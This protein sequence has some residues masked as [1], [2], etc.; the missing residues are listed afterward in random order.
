MSRRRAAAWFGVAHLVKAA[1]VGAGV[2]AGL[3]ARWAPV[4]VVAAALVA[5][6]VASGLG[7][8]AATRWADIAAR[9]AAMGA[10]AAGLLATTALGVTVSWLLGVYGPVGKGGGLLFA[11]VAALIFPY[12]V[13]L[14]CIELL[15]LRSWAKDAAER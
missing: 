7:L 1:L 3:P 11:L 12:L 13:V 4:D 14:P 9:V 2:F 6:D 8:L 5:L 10:L 15:W